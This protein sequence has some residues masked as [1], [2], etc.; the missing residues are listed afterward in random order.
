MAN[1]KAIIFDLDDTL[2]DMQE[3]R[4]EPAL[5]KAVTA[6][7]QSGLDTTKEDAF[8]IIKNLFTTNLKKNN[9]LELSNLYNNGT[10]DEIEKIANIG[11]KAYYSYKSKTLKPFEGVKE[12]LS[13]LE[14]KYTLALITFGDPDT[15]NKKIDQLGIREY[16]D[17]VTITQNPDKEE[18]FLDVI[19]QLGIKQNYMMTVG[20]RIDSEI[21]IGNKL[22]MS[23]TRLLKG[24]YKNLRPDNNLEEPDHTLNRINEL[25]ALL[26]DIHV[27]EGKLANGPKIVVIGGGTGLP[28]L[29]EGLK[30]YTQ[31]LYPIV[32]ITDEGRSSGKL[33][34]ELDILPPGDVRNNII[35]LSESEKLLHDLFQ[36]RFDEGTLKGHSL[37]NLLI[38]ALTKMTGN[39]QTAIREVGKI[40][41]IKGGV[42]P[43]TLE[44]THI[45]AELED[46]TILNNEQEIVLK[47][48][49]INTTMRA[50]I[51]RAFLEPGDVKGNEGAIQKIRDADIIVIGPGSLFT[52]VIP[53]LLIDDIKQSIKES[54][55][56]K[57]YTCNIVTQ[58]GQTDSYKASDHVK[59]IIKHLG[60]GILDH[61]IVNKQKPSKELKEQYAKDKSYI[62]ENDPLNIKKLGV[63][64]I[65]ADLIED[66]T[67][68]KVL[69]EKLYLLRHDSNKVAEIIV[70]LVND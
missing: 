36:Y 47:G 62:V 51:K 9:F 46:G 16:F 33:R 2:Y 65:E 10:K 27:K 60:E 66:I 63:I 43:A 55:A 54:R 39:F 49:K 31:R 1:I 59:M 3:Q 40:L 24:R 14:K 25:E 8:R 7:V 26:D 44:N 13:R 18:C 50:S 67:E 32:T 21:T 70:D 11:K 38:A 4:I 29:L 23:T 45:C 64:P 57:V 56:K 34:K 6:M 30:K 58:P 48:E 12:M 22:G 19:D 68:Q 69:W 42:Y 5:E 17:I 15:Q 53:N 28:T 52:S 37:G 35:A 41:N 20:D 61:A